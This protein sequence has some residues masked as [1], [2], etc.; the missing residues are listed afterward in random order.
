MTD[1][2]PIAHDG[3]ARTIAV[4]Y[5]SGYGHTTVLAESIAA[6][7]GDA[8]ANAMLVPVGDADAVDWDALDA[9][10]AIVFGSPTYM[11]SVSGPFKV[12]MDATSGR[13]M[14]KAWQDK[15][16]AGF[17]NS[18]SMSGDKLNTLVQLSVFAAQ[19]GMNW[20]STGMAPGN[21]HSQGSIDDLNRL[22]STLGVM[23][24][25]NADQGPDIV[26]PQSDRETAKVFGQRMA[27][28]TARW[29]AGAVEAGEPALG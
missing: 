23:A 18:A 11:G 17:T 19:H 20:V 21:N 6:G 1:Q 7:I 13:W 22:G 29:M 3:Q 8:G 27:A 4:A 16:A 28:A 14:E 10:D 15:L 12:F 24:Q 5:H 26:P 2:T 25:S 9:A